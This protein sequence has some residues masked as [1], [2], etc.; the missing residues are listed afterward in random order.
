MQTLSI[1]SI[2]GKR[3][4]FRGSKYIFLEILDWKTLNPPT[5][6]LSRFCLSWPYWLGCLASGF[7][8]IQFRISSKLNLEPLNHT[9]SPSGRGLQFYLKFSQRTV[10][11][12]LKMSLSQC[13]NISW[14]IKQS[15]CQKG[16]WWYLWNF[17]VNQLKFNS[18][19]SLMIII[20]GFFEY[21]T[22]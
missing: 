6:Q 5:R 22:K 20:K 14:E 10:G 16:V 7:Y 15:L 17:I 18:F 12:L 9:P 8:A 21:L 3:A 19:Y 4:W 1:R 2:L 11:R 13:Q